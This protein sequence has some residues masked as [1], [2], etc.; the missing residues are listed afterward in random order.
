M[1]VPTLLILVAAARL[2]FV[3]C[4]ACA[5]PSS[6]IVADQH[7]NVFFSDL[8]RGV[9]E[10]D[11]HGKV[12]TIFP[13]EGGHWLALDSNG[14]FSRVDFEKSPHWPRWFKLRTAPGVRPA[15]ISDGGSPLDVAPRWE[16][17]SCLMEPTNTC[18]VFDGLDT[19]AESRH[20]HRLR[21]KQDEM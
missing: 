19:M 2:S 1:R 18:H 15:L 17:L 7:G 21:L 13:R 12:S 20:W 9:L 6:G 16:P 8:D 3:P 5:H 4:A 14:A 10:I 11:A